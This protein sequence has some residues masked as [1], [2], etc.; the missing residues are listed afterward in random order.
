RS[1]GGYAGVSL[2]RYPR[3]PDQRCR[4]S[5]D[6]VFCS[7]EQPEHV[8]ASRPPDQLAVRSFLTSENFRNRA[9]VGN[10][11]GAMRQFLSGLPRFKRRTTV[12]VRLT[13]VSCA[14]AA[15]DVVLVLGGS[16]LRFGGKA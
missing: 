13:F 14:F 15:C 16:Q 12:H 5:R 2:A 7:R 10:D 6:R 9:S 3:C 11:R 1:W 8:A 4:L